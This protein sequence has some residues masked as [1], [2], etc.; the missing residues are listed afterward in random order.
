[1]EPSTKRQP[2]KATG[3]LVDERALVLLA[4][5]TEVISKVS[6]KTTNDTKERC[7]WQ[8]EVFTRVSF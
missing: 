4:G 8:T 5:S 7:G 3:T 6:G 1:M 2:T